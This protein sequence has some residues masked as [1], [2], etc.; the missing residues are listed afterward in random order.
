M[1]PRNVLIGKV[2]VDIVAFGIL[3]RLV[4]R[5]LLRVMDA[6]DYAPQVAS[7]AKD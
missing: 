4:M 2:F 7:V 1:N 3:L 6:L 5:S